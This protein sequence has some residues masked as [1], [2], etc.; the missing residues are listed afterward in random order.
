[1]DRGGEADKVCARKMDPRT[2]PA[3]RTRFSCLALALALGCAETTV[4]PKSPDVGAAPSEPSLVDAEAPLVSVRPHVN[5]PYMEAGAVEK[6]TDKLERE[7]REVIAERDEIVAALELAPGMVVADIGAGTGAFLQALSVAL[8]EHGKLY[9]ID[10]APQFLEHLRE[11]A[12][13]EA[14]QNV[15]VIEGSATA[16]MLPDASV[17]LLFLCDVYHHLEYPSVYLRS[18]HRALRPDGRMVIIDFEKIPGK[19]SEAMMKHVRQDE[20]TLLAEVTAEGF[21]LEREIESVGLDENYMLVFRKAAP[22]GPA[23]TAVAPPPAQPIE[24]D[25]A[26]YRMV[27]AGDI[28][29]GFAGAGLVTMLAG[30]VLRSDAVAQREALG[31]AAEPDAAAIARQ[32]QRIETGT[33]L[34][35]TGGA[36]AGA[37]FA[38]GI[39]LVAVGYA[40]E[41]KRREALEPASMA[42]APLLGPDRVGLSWQIHF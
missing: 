4:A 36:A 24:V 10:I 26:N 8:G 33:I 5:D 34:S 21:V 7:R 22:A 2:I 14:L 3:M 27:L 9:A 41:R 38:A 15:E 32:E 20:A 40:R 30:L 11:R 13:S 31:V 16:T 1:M 18:L 25:P 12:R 39:T 28:V 17:D 19:T 29:I 37:L 23:V 42:A 35:I 6:W